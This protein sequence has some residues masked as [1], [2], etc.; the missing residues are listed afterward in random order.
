MEILST[1][2]IPKR[3]KETHKGDYGRILLIGGNSNLGGAIML[4]ARACVNSGSGLITVA[5]HPTNHPALHANCPEAMVIDINDTKKLTKHIEATDC[6]LIGPGLGCD[7]KGNNAI[8][9][10]LQNI[11]PHQTL[12]IDG[13]AISIIS[14]LKPDIPACHVIYTPHQKEWE[15]LSGIPIEEQ[16][17]ERNRE[18]VDRLNATVVLKK[19]GT[20]IFFQEGEYKLQ[21][22]SP[23]MATGGMGD[24]L[25]G[26]ITSFV[27]QFENDDAVTSATYTHSYIGEELSKSMYVVPPSNLIDEIP[28]AMKRLED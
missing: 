22:G 25:A 6:I 23:A 18:A 15:R 2:S 26:M 3:K 7:F 16:T 17:Y 24:T 21:I 14:K 1:V 27:G 19:H 28:Y 5:T 13:D 8:T 12:I 20:E 4:A 10:L 11:Q 9:F